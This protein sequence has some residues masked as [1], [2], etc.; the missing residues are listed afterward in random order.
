MVPGSGLVP[1]ER[2]FE[3]L[4][5]GL[6]GA[7]VV[8]VTAF[9]G[10]LVVA[11]MTLTGALG[12]GASLW[13]LLALLLTVLA[14][15]VT[16][17]GATVWLAWL[18]LA[19]L[20]TGVA[21]GYRRLLWAGYRRARAFEE[22]SP[23]GRLLRPARIFESAGDQEGPLVTELKARY[24]AGELDEGEFERELGRLLGGGVETGRQVRREIAVTAPD[25]GD[26]DEAGRETERDGRE[27]EPETERG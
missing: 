3:L 12:P 20:R 13:V 21:A 9:L 23:V 22:G 11:T 4:L 27:R 18:A 1:S 7:G 14:A 16:A 19:Q 24:V 15:G 25:G 17:A 26:G 10:S 2:R 8:G 6:L 5:A